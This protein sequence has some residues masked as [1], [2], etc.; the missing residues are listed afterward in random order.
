VPSFSAW[1]H[2]SVVTPGIA[3]IFPP[4]E[5]IHH[6]FLLTRRRLRDVFDPR[7]LDEHESTD[8]EQD[9]HRPRRPCQLELRRA[10]DLGAI[11]EAI[12]S[13]AAV[14][15]DEG[16]EK[17]LDEHEDRGDEDRDEEPAVSDPF[18]IR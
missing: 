16:D 12:A 9:E 4:S 7:Q 1:N 13:L 2:V 17:S 14:L 15:P 5:G 8:E 18:G 3:S 6:E 11:L 10:V